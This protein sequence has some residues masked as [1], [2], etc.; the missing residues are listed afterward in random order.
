VLSELVGDPETLI[1]RL[2]PARGAASAP[3]SSVGGLGGGGV[4]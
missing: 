1:G 3:G 2:D 4:G